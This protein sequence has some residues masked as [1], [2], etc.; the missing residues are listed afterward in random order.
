MQAIACEQTDV[1]P[2]AGAIVKRLEAL[3]VERASAVVDTEIMRN[4]R[5]QLPNFCMVAIDSL[6][7]ADVKLMYNKDDFL[8]M[9]IN[10]FMDFVVEI[11]ETNPKTFALLI[12]KLFIF[13]GYEEEFLN[14]M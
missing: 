8:H 2:M 13:Y 5:N 9:D 7:A 14:A 6:L 4:S 11:A 10:S 3:L 12:S 1:C